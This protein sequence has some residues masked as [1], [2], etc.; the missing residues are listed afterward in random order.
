MRTQE[1]ASATIRDRVV[2]ASRSCL[3]AQGLRRTTVDDIAAAAGVSRA[4][5]Y[6][7]FPGGRETILGAVVATEREALVV[8]LRAAMSPATSLRD[9][10]VAG[11]LAAARWLSDHAILQRLMFEEPVEVLTHLEFESMDATLAV[12]ADTFAPLLSAHL[13]APA[14]LRAAEWVTRITVSYLLFPADGVDLTDPDEAATLVD[15]HV[16]PGVE[17]LREDVRQ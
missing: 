9:E 16:L 3:A 17:A 6:R 11:I 12:A 2:D 5:L 1:P 4:T 8:A 15:R 14:A 7:A 13:E 10:L